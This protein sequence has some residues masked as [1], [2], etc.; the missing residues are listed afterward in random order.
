MPG[1]SEAVLRVADLAVDLAGRRVLQDVSFAVPAGVV[2]GL[3]G[4]NGAG[5]TTLL[6]AIAGTRPVASGVVE[7]PAAIGYMPQLA[8]AVWDFPL[9]VIDVALQGSYRRTGWLRL[10]SRTERRR[11]ADALD[12]VGMQGFERRQI[13]QLSGG[14]RQRVLLARTLVQDAELV[15]LDEPMTGVDVATASLFLETLGRLRSQGRAVVISTHDLGWA[16]QNCD[17]ICLLAGTVHAFGPPAETL[18]AD[19]LAEV[20]GATTIEVGGVRILAPEGHHH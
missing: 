12:S 16:A 11:A 19:A 6:R 1:R 18:T 15:L 4:P 10:P 17:L 8:P 5:K 13:G 14:Q 2:V 9:A 3:V 20:Y 7:A